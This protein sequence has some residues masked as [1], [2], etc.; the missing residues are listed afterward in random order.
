MLFDLILY[1]FLITIHVNPM[2]LIWHM[3]SMPISSIRSLSPDK[4]VEIDQQIAQEN[5]R[6]LK[7]MILTNEDLQDAMMVISEDTLFRSV[8]STLH[9]YWDGSNPPLYFLSTKKK[10]N[11]SLEFET[12]RIILRRERNFNVWVDVSNSTNFN[13]DSLFILNSFF[14]LHNSLMVFS[15][16]GCNPYLRY[17]DI[18]DNAFID[19]VIVLYYKH[20]HYIL[21]KTPDASSLECQQWLSNKF[22]QTVN[23]NSKIPFFQDWMLYCFK[24]N[25]YFRHYTFGYG[26]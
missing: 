14:E 17:W 5:E 19:K 6:E 3:G 2:I 15:K 24:N 11:F 18:D 23:E 22:K 21:V 7:E 4:S 1:F 25:D 8:E 20:N 26:E 16:Y 13:A 9:R 10:Q 12:K